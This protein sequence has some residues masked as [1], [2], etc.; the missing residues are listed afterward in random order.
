MREKMSAA[1]QE[2]EYRVIMPEEQ[3][4]MDDFLAFAENETIKSVEDMTKKQIERFRDGAALYLKWD[5]KD[6]KAAQLAR[7]LTVY[8]EGQIAA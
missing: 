7:Q 3:K 4:A 2:K 8:F 5:G 6:P 1:V